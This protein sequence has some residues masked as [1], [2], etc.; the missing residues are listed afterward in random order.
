[1]ARNV[2]Q[3]VGHSTLYLYLWDTSPPSSN[4][5][6]KEAFLHFALQ[7]LPCYIHNYALLTLLIEKIGSF[8]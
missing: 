7:L 1:M 4:G 6:F 8:L 2:T 5:R 3:L